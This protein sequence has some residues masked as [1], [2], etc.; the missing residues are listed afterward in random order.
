MYRIMLVD[1][2][3]GILRA[4]KRVLAS[5]N[6]E[7]ET[8]SIPEEALERAKVSNFDMVI[9][10]YRMPKMDGVVFLSEFKQIHPDAVRI[11]LSGYSD[12][13]ALIGAVNQAEIF[14]FI[15]KPWHDFELKAVIVQALSHYCV[16]RENKRLA[17]QVRR[18]QTQLERQKQILHKLEIE[19]PGISQVNWAEDGSIIINDDDL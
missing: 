16:N 4:L 8:F 13:D 5:E 18:Q 19:S 15:S 6:Y 7:L 10:D 9:S 17:E 1:D 3:E 2:E 12:L 11:I 14:R